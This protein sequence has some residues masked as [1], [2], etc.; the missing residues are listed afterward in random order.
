MAGYIPRWFTRSHTVTH[1]STNRDWRRVTS[2]IETNA[3]PLSHATN[4]AAVNFVVCTCKPWLAAISHPKPSIILSHGLSRLASRKDCKPAVRDSKPRLW[5][6]IT[7]VFSYACMLSRRNEGDTSIGVFT[8]GQLEPCPS[9]LNCEKSRIGLWS[10]MQ[11]YK[12]CPSYFAR[13]NV[14]ILYANMQENH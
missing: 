2:L 3:L 4:T 8:T 6:L 7:R 1:P 11:P 12:S 14:C 5:G 9:H 13:C 10:K